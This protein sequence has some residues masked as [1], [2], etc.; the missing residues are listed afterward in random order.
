MA[1]DNSRAKKKN[2]EKSN[3]EHHLKTGLDIKFNQELIRKYDSQKQTNLIGYAI[4]QSKI[5]KLY[6]QYIKGL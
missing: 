2:N 5:S 6:K 4:H 3:N 1:L